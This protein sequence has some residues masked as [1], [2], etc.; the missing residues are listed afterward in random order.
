M[1]KKLQL[2]LTF[3]ENMGPLFIWLSEQRDAKVRAREVVS[4]VRIGHAMVHGIRLPAAEVRLVPESADAVSP[5]LQED[6]Q[7]RAPARK[8]AVEAFG[9]SFLVAT[10]PLQ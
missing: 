8:A 9:A 10:P 1:K 6:A 4:L 5:S 7:P 3:D 2:R